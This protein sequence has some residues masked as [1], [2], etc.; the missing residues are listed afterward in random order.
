MASRNASSL[1][2]TIEFL[3]LIVLIITGSFNTGFVILTIGIL[4]LAHWLYGLSKVFTSTTSKSRRKVALPIVILADCAFVTEFAFYALGNT[5]A[6][7]WSGISL[8]VLSIILLAF[9]VIAV[10]KSRK[11]RLHVHPV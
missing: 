9:T 4:I 1:A 11:M 10:F 7:E 6:I 3:G 8:M 2:L 5:L